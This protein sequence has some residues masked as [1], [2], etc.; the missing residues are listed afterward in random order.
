MEN[1]SVLGIVAIGMDACDNVSCS[2]L[3]RGMSY[4][5]AKIAVNTSVLGIV[6]IG[7]DAC[8]N[9]SCST[10]LRSVLYKEAKTQ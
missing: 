4:N 10:S 3:L 2:A 9:V 5:E 7:M 8:N 6:E 1:T